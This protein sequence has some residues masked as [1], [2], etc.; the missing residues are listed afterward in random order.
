MINQLIREIKI[1]S[2]L[3]HPNL[4]KLYSFF[5]DSYNVYLLMELGCDGQLYDLMKKRTKLKED[6]VSL[7]TREIVEGLVYMHKHK[8]IHRDIKPENI[9]LIHVILYPISKGFAKI[10][11]FGWSVYC[12]QD[13]RSTFCGTPLYLSPEILKGNLYN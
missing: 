3:D 9:V 11:D 1:Q 4:V 2:Y 5:D 6:T 7:I 13:L 10:C 8:V 12:S